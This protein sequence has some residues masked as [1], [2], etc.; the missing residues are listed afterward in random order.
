MRDKIHRSNTA[1]GLVR[2]AV[3]L[4][5]LG[6]CH[7][8]AAQASGQPRFT[9]E[10]KPVAA[11][12]L[13]AL[14][15]FSMAKG[16]DGKW[17]VVGGR[18]NGLHS[19]D[20]SSNN[21]T[22]APPN[23]FPIANAN[24]LLWVIDPAT[25]SSWSA[26]L[27]GLPPAIADSLSSTNAQSAQEGDTL[28][29]IG[30]YGW[31]SQKEQMTTFGMLNAILVDETIKAVMNK[32]DLTP[33]IQQTNTY[34]DC[35]QFGA[36]VYNTCDQDPNTGEPSCKTGPGWADCI[37]KVQAACRDKRQKAVQACVG[38]VQNGQTQ[39][40][41]NGQTSPIPAVTSGF[42]T[43]VT[44]GGLEKIG[45]VYYLVFG[46]DFEGLYSVKEGDYGK[47][48]VTQTYAEQVA[49]LQFK[50]NPLSAAV[51]NVYQQDPNDNSAPYHRRDLNVLPALAP[52]G[53]PRIVAHGGVF[54]PGQDSA[55]R[56][57]IFIDNGANPMNVKITVDKYEQVMSQYDCAVLK[58]FDRSGG[59]AG[60][61]IDVFFGGI[62][63]Y[64]LDAKT[65]KLKLDSGLPFINSVTSLTYNPDGSWSEYIRTAPLD[66]LMGS[67]ARFVPLS[68]IS[69]AENGV[70]NL[71]AI[72]GKTQIGY[73]YGGL[74]ASQPQAPDPSAKHT[75]SSN[76]LYEVWLDTSVPPPPGYW[77]SST[78]AAT[79]TATSGKVSGTNL[80]PSNNV[81]SETVSKPA[82]IATPTPVQHPTAK[83]KQ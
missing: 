7:Q 74:V 40:T 56:Q 26:P 52:D 71:D 9:V 72:K 51:L 36:N 30:G 20:Q 79:G 62:S 35:P 41:A 67:E 39:C 17:L 63:L 10:L 29:I 3:A 66:S 33:L 68:S 21:G 49:A 27:D 15:S 11:N 77:V 16:S 5:L 46:Q 4:T 1:R 38:C 45:N 12:N 47:W 2:G 61:M 31:D 69:A 8:A 76:A 65:G 50:A 18:T 13:P 37:K 25:A 80:H 60:R 28:Y 43:K 48:P 24:R 57:P 78:S 83:P 44:G 32:T 55:Y 34:L 53:T 64:Y 59:S 70:L 6:C 73:V 42:Y 75:K 22:T 81:L 19:F 23:A 14:H 82:S 54:V 58:M